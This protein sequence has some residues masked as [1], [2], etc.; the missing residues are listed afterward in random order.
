MDNAKTQ[1][2]DKLKTSNNILLTVSRNPSVDQLAACLGLTLVLN[3]MDKHA[4]AV[5][6]GE[7]P[8]TIEFLKPE[9]T[10]EKNTDSLRDFIISL[11]KSKADKLRYKVE[12]DVVRIFIT[13]Y[14]TSITESDFDFS[15]G[16]FNVDVVVALGVQDQDDIDT[17]I[18]AHGR[19][20]HDAAVTSINASAEGGL[21]TVNWH[22]PAAS[23]LSE[24]VVELANLLGEGLLDEQS[25]T[26]LLTGIVAET[27]RF[28][29]EKTSSET[30]RAS[31]ILM[32]VGADQQLVSAKLAEPVAPPEPAAE[33]VPE[34]EETPEAEEEEPKVSA[35]NGTI[36]IDHTAEEKS[37]K[38]APLELPEPEEVKAEEESTEPEEPGPEQESAEAVEEA[39]VEESTPAGGFLNEPPSMGGQLTANTDQE[40]EEPSTD[41][42][43]S[44]VGG[45]QPAILSRNSGPATPDM[46]PPPDGWMPKNEEP[47][48]EESTS[49]PESTQ[50]LAELESSVKSKEDSA[51]AA[52]EEIDKALNDVTPPPEPVQA[53]N[54]QPLGGALHMNIP[55]LDQPVVDGDPTAVP[56]STP[57]AESNLE[58]DGLNLSTDPGAPPAPTVIQP[59]ATSEVAAQDPSAPPSV[60]P[61][62]PFQ[63]GK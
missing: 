33:P 1:L 25:A 15:Q 46:T 50:T 2:V 19:I 51:E 48:A 23:S 36:E 34:V 54:A 57:P 56:A 53:L 9:E 38:E 45:E 60:P 12:D 41:P 37:E 10:I 59:T 40:N 29:N 7:T 26:A 32:A 16:D 5:Y 6:S 21:G 20:L 55:P 63:F 49:T 62:I 28:S 11:D 22:D 39:P 13:P 61:P 24:L 8:S 27:D 18:T 47:V 44:P 31:S 4:T 14:R 58:L 30:M 35:N 17:A 52:R 43:S 42:L 3:K